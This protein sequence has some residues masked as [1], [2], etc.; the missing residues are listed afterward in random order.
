MSS[1]IFIFDD[2]LL[3]FYIFKKFLIAVLLYLSYST[4]AQLCFYVCLT[5]TFIP[6]RFLG[7]NREFILKKI[8][9]EIILY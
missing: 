5:D 1:E 4:C 8:L 7:K 6:G 3:Q 9:Y 2:L